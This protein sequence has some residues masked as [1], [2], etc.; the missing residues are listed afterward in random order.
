MSYT[1]QLVPMKQT[2]TQ[3]VQVRY[4]QHFY[5]TILRIELKSLFYFRISALEVSA[6]DDL[7]EKILGRKGK[8]MTEFCKYDTENTG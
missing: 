8:L 5:K 3:S 4:C 7:R 6:I 2:K 1:L